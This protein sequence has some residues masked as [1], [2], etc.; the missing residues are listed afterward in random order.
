MTLNVNAFVIWTIF[1]KLDAFNGN[2]SVSRVV[3][4]FKN[5]QAS[6]SGTDFHSSFK[7]SFYSIP[8]IPVGISKASF[9]KSKSL[10]VLSCCQ[11]SDQLIGCAKKDLNRFKLIKW[12]MTVYKV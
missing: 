12:L 10:S 2:P 4:F 5:T 11:V 6:L 3:L 8:I 1:S 7:V 9:H